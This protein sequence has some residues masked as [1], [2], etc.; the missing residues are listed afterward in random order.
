MIHT[1]LRGPRRRIAVIELPRLGRLRSIGPVRMFNAD[2]PGWATLSEQQPST[3]ENWL[4]FVMDKQTQ[5]RETTPGTLTYT[6]APSTFSPPTQA[7]WNSW[8]K[9]A[10]NP[11]GSLVQSSSGGSFATAAP[12]TVAPAA[13]N[14]TWLLIAGGL[15]V[16]AALSSGKER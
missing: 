9:V 13:T 11:D 3:A 16:A 7:A 12:L 14:Y 4:A 1:T 10:C 2:V 8:G 15:I 5:R 6:P